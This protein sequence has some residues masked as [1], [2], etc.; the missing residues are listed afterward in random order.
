MNLTKQRFVNL[1]KWILYVAIP[2]YLIG[3]FT[4][5]KYMQPGLIFVFG[6]A[7]FCLLHQDYFASRLK[8]AAHIW[9]FVLV[10]TL[11]SI[12]IP[13]AKTPGVNNSIL[14]SITLLLSLLPVLL[15]MFGSTE[16][17]P[18]KKERLAIISF[19]IA[20]QIALLMAF[21]GV[22]AF[23]FIKGTRPDLFFWAMFHVA[24]VALLP[25]LFGRVICGWLCPNATFQDGLFKNMTYNRTESIGQ[26]GFAMTGLQFDGQND[27]ISLPQLQNNSKGLWDSEFTFLTENSADTSSPSGFSITSWSPGM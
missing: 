19:R 11:V 9:M 4:P 21:L 12:S 18:K 15:F 7:F 3:L 25:F 24:T 17:K 1:N 6:A 2:V 13:L 22:E 16:E 10:I 23:C 26:N 5:V 14:Y 20:F 8:S 27:F